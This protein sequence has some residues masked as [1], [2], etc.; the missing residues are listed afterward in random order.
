MAVDL[1]EVLDEEMDIETEELISDSA[2]YRM[3][4]KTVNW[5]RKYRLFPRT[6]TYNYSIESGDYVPDILMDQV[7]TIDGKTDKLSMFVDTRTR[8]FNGTGTIT[9]TI[10]LTADNA[11]LA[12]LPHEL[13]CLFVAY[14]KKAIGQRLKFAKYPTQPFDLDGDGLFSEGETE[15]K[16]WE[17][18]IMINRDEDPDNITDLRQEAYT[19]IPKP[20]FFSGTVIGGTNT[21][22]GFWR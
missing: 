16:E 8:I 19:G 17:E 9:V 3:Y 15:R 21:G 20:Y 12:G 1:R 6:N 13:E 14:C 7:V 2:L 5:Y 4:R 18:F 22:R 11:Y 10:A